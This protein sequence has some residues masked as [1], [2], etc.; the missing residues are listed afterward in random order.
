MK[1]TST[2]GVDLYPKVVRVLAETAGHSV[3][4]RPVRP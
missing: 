3:A 4:S 2:L 1:A